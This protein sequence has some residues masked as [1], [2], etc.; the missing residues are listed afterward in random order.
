MTL[1]PGDI[2]EMDFSGGGVMPNGSRFVTSG[3]VSVI[4]G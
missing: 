4:V 1:M 2:V 3:R